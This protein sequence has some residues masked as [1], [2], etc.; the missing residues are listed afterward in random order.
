MEQY[1][2]GYKHEVSGDYDG[3]CIWALDEAD[4]IKKVTD[5]VKGITNVGCHGV[6]DNDVIRIKWE[7]YLREALFGENYNEKIFSYV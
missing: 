7:E 6:F 2:V 5:R 3:Q 4:A 1:F